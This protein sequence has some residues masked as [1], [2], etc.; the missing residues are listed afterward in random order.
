MC[1]LSDELHW[2]PDSQHG[3]PTLTSNTPVAPRSTFSLRDPE[4][5]LCQSPLLALTTLMPPSLHKQPV[6]MVVVVVQEVALV[7]KRGQAAA[8]AV[9]VGC[10]I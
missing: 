9:H 6:M 5:R 2:H 4:A 7:L 3:S 8:A 10:T 1:R